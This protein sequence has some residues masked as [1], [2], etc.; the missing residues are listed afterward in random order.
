MTAE[1]RWRLENLALQSIHQ[2]EMRNKVRDLVCAD[3]SFGWHN[4]NVQ[5]GTTSAFCQSEVCDEHPP[6]LH[7]G[8]Q[9]SVLVV[10]AE[11][12]KGT[13]VLLKHFSV[14]LIESLKLQFYVRTR[15]TACATN[16][17]PRSLFAKL[18]SDKI[19]LL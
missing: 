6:H 9:I 14:L 7:S 17:I 19:N 12:K 2:P 16:L 1:G 4:Q 8:V 15:E 10:Y 3:N 18:I 11:R 13:K 5:Q